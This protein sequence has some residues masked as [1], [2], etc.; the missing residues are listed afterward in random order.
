MSKSSL[1]K[2]REA[3]ANKAKASEQPVN[4]SEVHTPGETIVEVIVEDP[5][6]QPEG[7]ELE[8]PVINPGSEEYFTDLVKAIHMALKSDEGRRLNCRL[9]VLVEGHK[10]IIYQGMLSNVFGHFKRDGNHAIHRFALKKLMKTHPSTA[11]FF[12]DLI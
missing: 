6:V 8:E 10:I 7:L 1:Q 9:H 3:K 12:K 5:E 11:Q 2:A 4:T